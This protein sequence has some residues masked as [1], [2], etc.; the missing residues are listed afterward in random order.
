MTERKGIKLI[1]KEELEKFREN[2]FTHNDIGWLLDRREE[3]PSKFIDIHLSVA[4]I[5]AKTDDEKI[6]RTELRLAK[7]AMEKGCE[8]V[9]N[10][11]YCGPCI[12]ATGAKRKSKKYIYNIL[13]QLSTKLRMI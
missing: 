3:D 5:N 12:A 9:T 8:Y 11:D 2:C 1:S 7:R 10:I 6:Y 4:Y 13:E